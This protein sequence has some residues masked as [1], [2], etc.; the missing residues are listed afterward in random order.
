MGTYIGPPVF[1]SGEGGDTTPPSRCLTRYGR[2]TS[3]GYPAL[4][5]C[6]SL[7]YHFYNSTCPHRCINESLLVLNQLGNY[8][9]RYTNCWQLVHWV[10]WLKGRCCSSLN[11]VEKADRRITEVKSCA[12]GPV[13]VMTTV[14]TRVYWRRGRQVFAIWVSERERC[15]S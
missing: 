11:V 2:E 6:T 9:G 12:L 13:I 15:Q 7:R 5:T 1:N 14:E 4:G 8:Y 10:Y 3:N